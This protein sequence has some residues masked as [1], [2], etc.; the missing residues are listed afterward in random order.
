MSGPGAGGRA[1]TGRDAAGHPARSSEAKGRE[2][3]GSAWASRPSHRE[4]LTERRITAARSRPLEVTRYE[5]ATVYD[6]LLGAN[7][8]THRQHDAARVAHMLLLA[9]GLAPRVVARLETF[10]LEVAEMFE[11]DAERAPG[12]PEAPSPRDKYRAIM[13][14]LGGFHAGLIEAMLL[15]ESPTRAWVASLAAGLDRLGDL[16]GLR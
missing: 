11:P 5:D 15:G 4:R 10:E 6:R 3:T 7:L 1:G 9:A 2:A 14:R 12:D 13:R 16:L 8:I